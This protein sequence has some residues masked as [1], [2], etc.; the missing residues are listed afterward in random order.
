MRNKHN[1]RRNTAFLFEVLCRDLTKSILEKNEKRKKAIMTIVSEHFRKG[2]LLSQELSYYKALSDPD[3]LPEK[4]AEKVVS[5][6]VKSQEKL[7]QEKL[8]AEQSSLINRINKNLGARV[9]DNFVPNYQ[10]LATI[11]QIFSSKKNPKKRV[12]L[13]SKIIGTLI[14]GATPLKT[15]EPIDNL[16]LKKFVAK[17]NTAYKDELMKEQKV[18]LGKYIQSVASNDVEFKLYLNEEIGRLKEG[19]KAALKTPDISQDEEMMSKTKTVGKILEGFSKR[20]L[21]E[22][23]LIQ[24][25]KVQQLLSELKENTE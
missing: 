18:L 7:N 9:Y 10:Y 20:A 22:E 17:F 15:L 23:M 8:F 2:T 4:T 25:L 3:N 1:K 13:E 14:N 16:I 24:M 21:D 19:V 11:C 5:A 12:M 6:T